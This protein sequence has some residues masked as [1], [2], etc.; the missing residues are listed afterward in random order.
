[1][2]LYG[3]NKDKEQECIDNATLVSLL[4][5]DFQQDFGHSSDQRKTR[6]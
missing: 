1:M 2:T 3:E 6:K 4:A 5:K